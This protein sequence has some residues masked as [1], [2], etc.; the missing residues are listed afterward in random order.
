MKKKCLIC[1]KKLKFARATLRKV[2][3]VCVECGIYYNEKEPVFVQKGN[4][5]IEI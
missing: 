5:L 2:T 4:I 3:D 1:K